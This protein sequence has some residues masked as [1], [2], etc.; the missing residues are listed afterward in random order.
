M[1]VQAQPK[2]EMTDYAGESPAVGK[3]GHELP[4]SMPG[5]VDLCLLVGGCFVGRDAIQASLR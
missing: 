4:K 1:S 2:L 3:G 5:A